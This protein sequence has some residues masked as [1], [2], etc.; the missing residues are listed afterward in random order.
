MKTTRSPWQAFPESEPV[1]KDFYESN[2]TDLPHLDRRLL[3]IVDFVKDVQPASLLDVACG[4]GALLRELSVR[5]PRMQ[6]VGCDI[7]QG[8]IDA[9]RAAGFQA[10]VENVEEGLTYADEAF[11]CVVFG[12]V[13]EHLVDPDRA[14][15]N[16]SRVLK[17][18]GWLILTTPNLASW[19][20][21][22]LLPLGIQPIF[23]E[24]S[25]HVNLGRIVPG[26]G[27][28]KPTQGH[29]KVFTWNAL[30][31]MLAANGFEVVR[32]CGAPFHLPNIATPLDNMLAN[33]PKLASNFVVLASNQRTL[34]TA[35]TRLPNW[36]SESV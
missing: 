33:F 6:V 28:W 12:E 23:T 35:Y 4:R 14:L 11:E 18:D 34:E 10:S 31:E 22:V 16:I 5:F 7:S 36:S 2:K 27:Q 20:N 9:V 29:L 30:R 1:S 15:Q 3:K 32:L 8:S 24:T 13:I 21:R 25:I 26:L 19:F 17:K